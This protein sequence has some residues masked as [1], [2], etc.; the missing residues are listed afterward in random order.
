LGN[1]EDMEPRSMYVAVIRGKKFWLP[2][3]VI[4]DRFK[5]YKD[6]GVWGTACPPYLV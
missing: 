3:W 1:L 2:Q 6:K 5:K 4:E